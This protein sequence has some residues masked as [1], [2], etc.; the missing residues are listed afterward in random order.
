MQVHWWALL[1][2]LG[3]V[4]AWV[5]VLVASD[6]RKEEAVSGRHHWLGEADDDPYEDPLAG[7]VQHDPEPCTAKEAGGYEVCEDRPPGEGVTNRDRED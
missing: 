5:L 7:E 3:L 2:I 1:G 6:P 4:V